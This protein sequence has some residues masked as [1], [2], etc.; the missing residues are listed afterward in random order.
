MSAK[1]DGGNS[2]VT[3]VESTATN[4]FLDVP[5]TNGISTPESVPSSVSTTGPE[6]GSPTTTRDEDQ[7][8]QHVVH[9]H[10]NPGETFTV[11]VGD[12]FQHIP[13]YF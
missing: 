5:M 13:G 2:T 11:Q 9:V 12:Q 7:Q 6:S 10:I 3:E 8:Q 1:S 4:G